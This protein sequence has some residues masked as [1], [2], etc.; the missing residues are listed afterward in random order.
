LRT[1]RAVQQPVKTAMQITALLSCCLASVAA[2]SNQVALFR[3]TP[4]GVG[5]VVVV[6]PS[7]AIAAFTPPG[8]ADITLESLDF[9]GRTDLSSLAPDSPRLRTDVPGAQRIE[10]PAHSGS[11]YC[12]SRVPSA[13]GPGR[14]YGL[15]V[16]DASGAA[17]SVFEIQGVGPAL[18]GV[19]FL[20]RVAIAGDG[21]HIL[22]AT[23]PTAGGDLFEIEL[24]TG[25]TINRTSSIPP[26]RFAPAGLQLAPSWGIAATATGVLRFDRASSSNA[27]PLSF[28]GAAPAW[29]SG[30]VVLSGSGAHAATIA[31]DAFD[32]ARVFA[33]DP[34]GAATQVSSQPAL[35]SGAGFLPE[36]SHGP[37]LAISDDGSQC[38]WRTEGASREAFVARVP[39]AQPPFEEQVTANANYMDTL[40]EIGQFVFR[41]FSTR[42]SIA[43]GELS[44]NGPGAIENLD[45][46]EVTLP[47]SGPAAIQNLTLSNGLAQPPFNAV[48]SLKPDAL[49]AAPASD[50]VVFFNQRSG[51]TGDLLTAGPTSGGSIVLVPDVKSVE[52]I[53]RAGS[54]L[55]VS[56]RRSVGAKNRELYRIGAP[57]T[58][59]SSALLTVDGADDFVRQAARADGTF[60]FV[61]HKATAESLWRLTPLA[62]A[63]ALFTNRPLDY[64]PTLG[65][66]ANG[67][68][69]FSVD[70][71][72]NNSIF[73]LWS[74]NGPVHRLP[75][76]VGPGFVLP[77]A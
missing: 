33:F 2:G 58:A 28:S 19:P 16:V 32:S 64:G 4:G 45:V 42:L 17:R 70:P 52:F 6:D 47:A 61:Q 65:F 24:A 76:P 71:G 25:H 7:G 39:L 51:G 56:L 43:V 36:A 20:T 74:S 23:K 15:F 14:R 62:P 68:A 12:Y 50:A 60:V 27:Q 41:A 67:G 63:P 31:G 18:A 29:F 34:I 53:E 30:E 22:L 48:S 35:L 75:V 54:D 44:T 66:A 59:A 13:G 55:L 40:D 8:L 72:A 5:D 11:L 69:V 9:N 10:L 73:A 38:A 46:Y 77:G 1:H 49:I 21:S 26:Q 37:Y 3:G 57:Y